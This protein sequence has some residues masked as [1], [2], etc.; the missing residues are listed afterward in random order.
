MFGVRCFDNNNIN[1][2]NSVAMCS[3]YKPNK[4]HQR[5]AATTYATQTHQSGQ[6][7]AA[8]NSVSQ[9]VS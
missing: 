8:S 2:T 7:N 6:A 4:K 9:S 5:D 1:N 3:V